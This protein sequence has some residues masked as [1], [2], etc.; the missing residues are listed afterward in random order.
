[1]WTFYHRIPADQEIIDVLEKSCNLQHVQTW[2]DLTQFGLICRLSLEH[3]CS[4]V[5]I[6]DDGA[7]IL[8]HHIWHLCLD[9][10]EIPL[11]SCNIFLVDNWHAIFVNYSNI[12]L[13]IQ[14]RANNNMGEL[15]GSM[16]LVLISCSYS[17]WCVW[18][19]GVAVQISW[20]DVSLVVA[21]ML[22]WH[23]RPTRSHTTPASTSA[24]CNV[25][26]RFG[27][28]RDTSTRSLCK[29]AGPGLWPVITSLSVFYGAVHLVTA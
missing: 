19:S 15:V 14:Q 1:M 24:L 23:S 11:S 22:Y 7:Q 6:C 28:R 10:A 27:A 16:Q 12:V 8:L 2:W 3:I 26:F 18:I 4:W 20:W 9:L 5:Q 21:N 25:S 29:L 13:Y 17:F